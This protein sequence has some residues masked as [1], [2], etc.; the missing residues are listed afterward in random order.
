MNAIK[1]AMNIRQQEEPKNLLTASI[2]ENVLGRA[3][4]ADGI[5][6][7]ARHGAGE[8][9]LMVAGGVCDLA[10]GKVTLV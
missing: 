7:V 6:S 9:K 8:K 10:A 2:A 3:A 1:P 5:T 4:V